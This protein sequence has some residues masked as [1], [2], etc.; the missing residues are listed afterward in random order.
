M[1]TRDWLVDLSAG[2]LEEKRALLRA[3]A[4]KHVLM[5]LTCYPIA[6]L[7]AE[8]PQLKLACSTLFARLGKCEV[9]VLDPALKD[10]GLGRL[11]AHGFAGVETTITTLGFTVARTLV[12]IINEAYWALHDGVA[13][14]AAIDRAMVF[15]VGYPQGP[16]AWARGQERAVA[17]LLDALHA[18][19]GDAR[20]EAAPLLRRMA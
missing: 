5:D 6:P 12:T 7:A 17:A 19:T 20:Y 10:E 16:F 13:D 2:T 1:S 3:N 18:E 8:F 15:G 9:V 11:A 14:A 4:D